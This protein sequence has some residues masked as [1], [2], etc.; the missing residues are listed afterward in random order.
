MQINVLFHTDYVS[1]NSAPSQILPNSNKDS[2]FIIPVS[3]FQNVVKHY[4][5]IKIPYDFIGNNS[6]IKNE[7]KRSTDSKRIYNGN[8]SFNF[9]YKTFITVFFSTNS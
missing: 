9:R 2:D 4:D 3:P 6:H 8:Y 7:I 5:H 1:D